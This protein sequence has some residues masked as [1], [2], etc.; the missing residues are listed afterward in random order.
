[1]ERRGRGRKHIFCVHHGHILRW[2]LQRAGTLSSYQ[3]PLTLKLCQLLSNFGLCGM[4]FDSN[5]I[6]FP[7]NQTA[8]HHRTDVQASIHWT[9]WNKILFC[10]IKPLQLLFQCVGKLNNRPG[11]KCNHSISLKT[12]KLAAIIGCLKH[13]H[14]HKDYSS[15]NVNSE[16]FS[17]RE[18][19]LDVE[20]SEKTQTFH[21]F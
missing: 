1:M 9:E 11:N 5:K 19:S 4:I 2:F 13:T 14:T 17:I 21:I 12:S 6:W 18:L 20:K 8:A 7:T 16:T 3:L 15:F 10:T